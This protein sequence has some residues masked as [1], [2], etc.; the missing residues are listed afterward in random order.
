MS[1]STEP[2]TG[3]RLQ[4]VLPDES[5]DVPVSTLIDLGVRADERMERFVAA[6]R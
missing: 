1:E 4:V 2:L 5:P 6:V 3:I